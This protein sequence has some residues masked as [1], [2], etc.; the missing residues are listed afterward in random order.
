MAGFESEAIEFSLDKIERDETVKWGN[1]VRG[2]AR[3]LL[4][5]HEPIG[6]AEILV[7]TNF[8]T[9]GRDV[10]LGGIGIMHCLW[11]DEFGGAKD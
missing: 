1:Y 5:A 2:V 9:S 10:Q 11:V 8:S 7:D 3:E 6:G 4:T